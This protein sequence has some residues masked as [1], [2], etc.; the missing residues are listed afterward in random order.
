MAR[1]YDRYKNEIAPKLME[2]LKEKNRLAVPRLQ[3]IVVNMGIGKA[4]ENP[5]RI[6]DATKSLSLITGQK[7]LVTKSKK[8]IS[9]FKL[10][11]G[12]A[13]GCKVT[14]RGKR[15]YEFLDRLVNIAIPRIRDFRGLPRTAFDQQGNYTLGIHEQ[16]IFPEISPDQVEFSQGMDVTLTISNGS[17]ERS[18]AM[19]SM[20]GFPFRA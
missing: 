1:L 11:K 2:Q 9:G 10:R 8:A 12:I 14:L 13:I 18:Y 4:I 20:F 16:T 6:E 7:P 17:P 15:M 19:L 3:K 5:K